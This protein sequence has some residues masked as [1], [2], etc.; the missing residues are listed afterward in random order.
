MP[1]RAALVLPILIAAVRSCDGP[2]PIERTPAQALQD[3]VGVNVHLEYDD[4]PYASVARTD[5]AL[6]LIGV[7]QVRDAAMR[8]G[9]TREARFAQLAASGVRFDLFFSRDP[10]VQMAAVR[11]LEA[12]RPDA[13]IS[14]EGPNEANHE[15]YEGGPPG[16]RPALQAYQAKLYAGVHDADHQGAAPVLSFTTWPP[17]AGRADAANFHAYPNPSR[18]VAPQISWMRRMAQA[19]EPRRS[20]V[21]CTETG[22]ATA[23]LGGVSELRQA[24]LE[25]VLLLESYRQGVAKTYLYE[26]F[27]EHADP[28]GRAPEV[29]NHWGLFT[30]AGRPKPAA[31]SVRRFM[32]VLRSGPAAQAHA[33]P[34]LRLSDPKLRTLQV[35][36]SDGARVTFTWWIDAQRGPVRPLDVAVPDGAEAHWVE[37]ST[38]RRGDLGAGRSRVIAGASPLAFVQ[39]PASDGRPRVPK[40]DRL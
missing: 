32:E 19:V 34:W 31:E 29:E 28:S 30:A 2:A 7:R 21:I 27:D 25:P 12:E 35:E 15:A 16:D 39:A 11:R 26:L 5:A 6:M 33:A 18:A 13:V 14:F 22:F 20:P 4:T 10:V 24:E 17:L 37:L 38:G 1:F 40:T 8:S 23:G 36:R 9:A 3:S